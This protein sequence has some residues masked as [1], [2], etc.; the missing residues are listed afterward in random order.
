MRKYS[1]EEA[2]EIG[3]IVASVTTALVTAVVASA[4]GVIPIKLLWGWT[5]PDLFPAAVVQ[6]LIA[7]GLT[8]LAAVKIA[9]LFTILSGIG[10]LF[11]GLWGR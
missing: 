7:P 4:I 10:A 6:G 1:V 3:N 5:I 11:V 8:W 9:A 2:I